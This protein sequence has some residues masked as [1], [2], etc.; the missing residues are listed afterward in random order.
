MVG[1]GRLKLDEPIKEK[2]LAWINY[3]KD[4]PEK[5][6]P[7]LAILNKNREE[8][9]SLTSQTAGGMKLADYDYK[10]ES[11]LHPP[12]QATPA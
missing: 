11:E 12:T 5:I 9:N 1:A 8:I 10:N 7:H 2:D 3:Y 4:N 6:R